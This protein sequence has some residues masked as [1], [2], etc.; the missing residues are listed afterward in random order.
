MAN[1]KPVHFL[2]DHCRDFNGSYS[3]FECVVGNGIFGGGGGGANGGMRFASIDIDGGDNLDLASIQFK[4]QTVGVSSGSWKFKVYGIK[5]SD[6]ADFGSTPFGRPRTTAFRTYNEGPP[7][8]GGTKSIDVRDIME[9]IADQGGWSR[10]NLVG[11]VFIDDGSDSNVYAFASNTLSYLVY[12]TSPEPNFTPTPITVAA[13]T[14]PAID[15]YG[16]KIS[17][18][19]VSVLNATEDQLLFTT[20]KDTLKIVSQGQVAT[21]ANVNFNSPHGLGYK[22][23]V[24]GYARKNGY[25]FQLP[26]QVVGADDPVGSGVQGYITVDDTNVII[27]TTVNADVYYYIFLDE[28]AS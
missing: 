2:D 11:F 9:E 14:F 22:P 12:R 16:M 1:E 24:I 17:Y 10:F 26:R 23:Q 13:P 20:R 21:T 19:G 18:P 8:A 25:S 3:Q 27:N 4:Y 6:T 28:Q 5:E 7:T 15:N